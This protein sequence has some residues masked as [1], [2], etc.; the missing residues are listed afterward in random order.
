MALLPSPDMH[1]CALVTANQLVGFIIYWQWPDVLFIEHFAIDPALRGQ[2]FGQQA[3]AQLV[4][5]DYTHVI[6]EVERP[7][8]ETSQRRVRFYERQ[9]LP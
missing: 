1:L 6:L 4:R 5:T 9:G 7:E 2:Q 3:L 8:D